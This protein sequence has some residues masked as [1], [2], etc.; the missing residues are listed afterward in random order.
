MKNP[1]ILR[2]PVRR[3]LSGATRNVFPRNV[4]VAARL[5]RQSQYPLAKDVPHHLGRAALDRVG[6]RAQKLILR[7]SDTRLA[8]ARGWPPPRIAGLVDQRVGADHVHR[9]F[10]D[11]FVQFSLSEFCDCALGPRIA[12]FARGLPPLRSHAKQLGLDIE[13]RDSIAHYRFALRGEAAGLAR[14]PKIDQSADRAATS[15]RWCAADRG[16]LVHQSRDRDLPALALAP[17]DP[18]G[19]NFHIGEENF[20]ELRLAGD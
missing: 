10:P 18:V 20:V 7:H 11:P 6:A 14:F 8:S 4:F 19:R 2:L 15:A 13:T 3:F 16:P 17:H 1:W 9:A 12:G 5:T